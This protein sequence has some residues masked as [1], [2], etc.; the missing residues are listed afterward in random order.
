MD[1][2]HSRPAR[3]GALVLGL[4]VARAPNEP[5]PR[6]SSPRLWVSV[7]GPQTGGLR[8][9]GDLRSRKP[10]PREVLRPGARSV[11]GSIPAA[12]SSGSTF[13]ELMPDDRRAGPPAAPRLARARVSAVA[14]DD[15]VPCEPLAGPAS[16]R[17][18]ARSPTSGTFG[19]RE[20]PGTREAVHPVVGTAAPYPERLSRPRP[21][22]APLAC[23]RSRAR[24]THAA[25][26]SRWGARSGRRRAGSLE[27]HPVDVARISS[28]RGTAERLPGL[29]TLKSSLGRVS[30][31]AAL[32]LPRKPLPMR[33]FRLE[34]VT[35]RVALARSRPRRQGGGSACERG[36]DDSKGVPLRTP[37]AER[38][39]S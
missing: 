4:T 28:P 16:R 36:R 9:A 13:R 30:T 38:S 22:H 39:R 21:T 1:P 3:A 24:G 8:S 7:L 6:A 15:E 27:P 31:C 23:C 12:I 19:G 20:C 33:G 25:R 10:R 37:L 26:S 2:L 32:F 29:H 18:P 34:G 35:L 5:S 17:R 14:V 11:S